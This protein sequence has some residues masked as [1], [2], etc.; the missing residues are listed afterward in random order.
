MI[1]LLLKEKLLKEKQQ[2]YVIYLTLLAEPDTKIYG[3]LYSKIRAIPGVTIVKAAHDSDE[4]S[5][6]SKMYYLK[7]KFLS[8]TALTGTFVRHL[9]RS[10]LKLTDT[11]GNG[12][13]T[14]Q[15]NTAPVNLK[16][17]AA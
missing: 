14:V 6:G 4:N 2:Q 7:I 12:I 15:I 1:K 11:N 16:T 5:V 8:D 17:L 3:E 10:I 13:T 9:K